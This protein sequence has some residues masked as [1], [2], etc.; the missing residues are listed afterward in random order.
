MPPKLPPHPCRVSCPY[1]RAVKP[2][3]RPREYCRRDA[4]AVAG[5]AESAGRAMFEPDAGAARV[6]SSY[7]EGCETREER[8]FTLFFM[9]S[10]G[11]TSLSSWQ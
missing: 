8:Y 2:A 10:K 7:R 5:I 11:V 4:R 1:P 6:S 9:K 3:V